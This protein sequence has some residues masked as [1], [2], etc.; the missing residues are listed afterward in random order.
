MGVVTARSAVLLRSDGTVGGVA[1]RE[2]WRVG[3]VD[4]GWDFLSSME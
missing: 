1:A 2:R 3:L 4:R